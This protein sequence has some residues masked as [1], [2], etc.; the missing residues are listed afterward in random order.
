M[1]TLNVL[2]F[3]ASFELKKLARSIQRMK[4]L[5]NGV[6]KH[7]PR[8]YSSRLIIELIETVLGILLVALLDYFLP[9]KLELHH[10]DLYL[11]WVVV[12]GIAA[13]YGAPAG[14]VA[15]FL[16]A[17]TFQVLISV[18]PYEV[19]S[20]HIIIQPFLLFSSGI[21]VSQLVR[22]H[23]V[24]AEQAKEKLKKVTHSLMKL[25]EK[26]NIVT[27]YKSELERRIANQP[28]SIAM[29]SEF[30]G[31]MS[32]L[33]TR[34]LPQTIEELLQSVLDVQSCSIYLAGQDNKFRLAEKSG[35]TVGQLPAITT[36]H[37]TIDNPLIQRAVRE[38]RVI[39][40]RDVLQHHDPT[41]FSKVPAVIAG[42]L[43]NRN[44]QLLGII[45]IERIPFFR[46][47]PAN[48]RLFE[49]LLKWISISFENAL[50]F[51]RV[52]VKVG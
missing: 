12:L 46:F 21:L 39:T 45:L 7:I 43:I 20:P 41:E 51:E 50:V 22:I 10:L 33:Q 9:R 30:A 4:R 8:Q 40:I 2:A 14:Y 15:S 13:R 29:M 18:D 27:D 24:S 6:T 48:I 37:S 35:S 34:D 5:T 42:P 19:L 17:I 28:I 16:A 1:Q 32:T 44:G 31:R 25:Q 49:Q 26:Y 11:L 52:E 36:K 23:K 47:T 3:R 38:K